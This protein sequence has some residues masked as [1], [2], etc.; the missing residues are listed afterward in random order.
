[1]FRRVE[2]RYGEVSNFLF[3]FPMFRVF[4]DRQCV[5]RV[6]G[7]GVIVFSGSVDRRAVDRGHVLCLAVLLSSVL[8]DHR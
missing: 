2:E 7:F 1:M 4:V 6:C 5:V 3:G 8:A